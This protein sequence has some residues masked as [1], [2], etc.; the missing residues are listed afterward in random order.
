MLS[1]VHTQWIKTANAFRTPTAVKTVT[2][3]G[4]MLEDADET[5]LA[6]PKPDFVDDEESDREPEPESDYSNLKSYFPFETF[7]KGQEE[8]IAN[9]QKALENPKI[10]IIL[11]EAPTGSGKSPLAIMSSASSKSAYIATANKLLQEQYQRDFKDVLSDLKGRTNYACDK[12]EGKNCGDSPC[13]VKKN[14]CTKSCG[15]HRARNA[16]IVSRMTAMNFAALL[17]QLNYTGGWQKR[18]LLVCD[19][20]HLLPENLTEFGTL[21][22]IR[23]PLQKFQLAVDL[24]DYNSVEAY[25]KFIENVKAAAESQV[26][27]FRSMGAA[28]DPREIDELDGLLRKI[29]IFEKLSTTSEAKLNLA[30]VKTYHEKQKHILMTVSFKPI[31]VADVFKRFVLEHAEKFMFLSATILDFRTYADILGIKPEETAVIQIGSNFPVKNR[32][33]FTNRAIGPINQGN[34]HTLMPSLVQNIDG[35]L[36]MYPDKKGIIFASS[37]QMCNAICDMTKYSRRILYPRKAMEQKAMLEEHM[38]TDRPT[39]LISPSMAEGVDLKGEY[40]RFQIVAKMPYPYLGDPV[41]QK[42]KEIYPNYYTYKTILTLVQS[43]GR[44]VRDEDD[45]AHTYIL[46]KSFWNLY[47]RRDILPGWFLEAVQR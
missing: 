26:E 2:V 39:V 31:Q 12:Y 36:E 8:T 45:W 16:A 29:E 7:R 14:D 24:P 44:S 18:N 27:S 21:T 1:P 4:I 37:Y 20:A 6:E 40:S 41:I 10:R 42:R 5:K 15:Y 23:E 33:I 38:R 25:L 28:A 13:R 47:N 32:P 34:L 35:I 9:L 46:D 30:L 19:E 43:Y 17:S 22:F 3:W 11:L